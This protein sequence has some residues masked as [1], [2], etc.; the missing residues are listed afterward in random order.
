M[1]S[2]KTIFPHRVTITGFL[3]APGQEERKTIRRGV[4]G[5]DRARA[6]GTSAPS[7]GGSDHRPA[8]DRGRWVLH[9]LHRQLDIFLNNVS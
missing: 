2:R 9:C 6:G 4:S 5:T 1:R 3:L 8:S 7:G